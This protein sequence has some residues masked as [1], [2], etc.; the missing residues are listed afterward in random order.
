MNNTVAQ[1]ILGVLTVTLGGGTV[2]LILAMV[3]RRTDLRKTDTE[4]DVNQS[5][6]YDKIIQRL[7]EDA[8]TYREQARAV[9][10]EAEALKERHR[11]EL[12]GLTQRLEDAH[13]EH[14]RLSSTIARLRNDLDIANRQVDDMRRLHP[15][16]TS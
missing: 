4:S 1:L 15:G 7:Q 2:Q 8:T 5:T 12:R 6:V 9:H 16:G 11:A 10:T 13:T 3:R 14:S